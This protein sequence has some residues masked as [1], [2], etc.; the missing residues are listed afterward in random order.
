[1]ELSST[2]PIF[3]ILNDLKSYI[4][5]NKNEV[6]IKFHNYTEWT[7]M[8]FDNFAKVFRNNY[9]ET[10]EDEVL[11]VI[12]EDKVLKI[13]KIANIIKYCNSNNHSTLNHKWEN[14]EIVKNDLINN[15]FDINLEFDVK[16]I[17]D[18]EE[19]PDFNKKMKIFKLI[20][21]FRYDIGNGFEV[22]GMMIKTNN[23]NVVDLKKSKIL[24]G[25]RNY[26]FEL[27]VK[28]D[29][30]QLI[31]ENIINVLKSFFMT[32][33][34]LTKKQQKQVL[35]D[36]TTL[37]K[38]GMTIPP[39]FNEVPLLTPKPITL[40]KTNLNNPDDYGA[41]SI[42]KNYVVTEKADGERV[43]IY[44][45]NVGKV[46]IIRSSLKVEET[47]IIA[48]KEAFN[49]LIDGEYIECHKRTDGS[50]KNLIASFDI[51]YQKEEQ[52]TSLSLIGDN[53]RN[54]KMIKIKDYLDVSKCNIEFIV[55]GEGEMRMFNDFNEKIADMCFTGFLVENCD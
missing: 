55:K 16:K 38:K 1:M 52:L 32:N 19:V 28:N 44:I 13:F 23:K 6:S 2:D 48:K 33:I 39:Y 7:E 36:Y 18:I 14:I 25:N 35:D 3:K 4:N 46:F 5:D 53:S 21:K 9:K 12:S 40:E 26:E 29:N 54:S 24:T 22:V 20:K 27:I 47:G 17:E 8:E 37:V 49:S 51:Y 50:S 11:E 15:L 31:L 45:N 42:L 30:R 34:L 43:L 41:V 10:I